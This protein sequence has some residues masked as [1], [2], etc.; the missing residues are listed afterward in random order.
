V[1]EKTGVVGLVEVERLKEGDEADIGE[2]TGLLEAIH[3]IHRFFNAE[4]DVDL[5]LAR[6]I[7]LYEGE[8]R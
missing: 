5:V 2:L 3:R 6:F 7:L 1:A 4:Q 8:K